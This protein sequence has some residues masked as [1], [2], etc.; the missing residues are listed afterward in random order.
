ME[1]RNIKHFVALSEYKHFSRAAKELNITQPTLS[2]SL[3][4]L[5]LLVGGKLFLRDSKNMSMTPL[6]K[7]MLKHGKAILKE[8]DDMLQALALFHGENELTIIIGASPIPS[9]SLVGPILGEYINSRPN[10]TL[11]L[12]VDGW[13]ELTQQLL[14]GELDLF[15]AE[16]DFNGLDNQ[17]ELSVIELPP[18]PVVFCCRPD[19][20]LAKLSLLSLDSFRDY[21]LA[22]PRHLPTS[23]LNQFEG[24]FK[25]R[26]NFC[27]QIRF[28]QFHSIKDSI[29]NAD[30]V[31]LTPEIAVRKEIQQG[32]L[33]ALSPQ[34]MPK[35][36]AKFSIITL[37]GKIQNQAVNTF[38]EHLIKRTL[39]VN[40]SHQSQLES[41]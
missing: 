20:P 13:K 1:L 30:L 6:G 36:T 14:E 23:I 18:F 12:S 5:E 28:D 24:L 29:M 22:I 16:S 37:A 40:A 41:A 25:Q 11:E 34:L 33:I 10:M 2:K 3:Q 38:I 7:L 39:A 17:Y 21:S 4:K 26:D 8:H 32:R 31:A 15:V 27:G 19:H 9:N 35:L